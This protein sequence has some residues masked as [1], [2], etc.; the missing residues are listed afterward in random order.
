M[1]RVVILRPGAS[2]LE[3][4]TR[5]LE[6]CHNEVPATFVSGYALCEAIVQ[7]PKYLLPDLQTVRLCI[8][9]MKWAFEGLEP[10]QRLN[11]NNLW[12]NILLRL[13]SYGGHAVRQTSLP[14]YMGY[15][16]TDYMGLPEAD[17]TVIIFCTTC[18]YSSSGEMI[19]YP[20]ALEN[21][22]S[23]LIHTFRVM[24]LHFLGLHSMQ[25]DCSE[26]SYGSSEDDTDMIRLEEPQGQNQ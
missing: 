13:E 22:T 16:V 7:V 17:G 21:L 8:R 15:T 24:I 9:G 20:V 25:C 26:N 11:R 5:T 10:V 3:F 12:R 19:D 23:V 1:P 4:A 2:D 6:E 18:P 14:D